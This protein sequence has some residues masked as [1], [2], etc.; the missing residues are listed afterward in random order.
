MGN[1]KAVKFVTSF[2]ES[3]Q[4][5]AIPDEREQ[6]CGPAS[7]PGAAL[8]KQVT[9]VGAKLGPCDG[10]NEARRAKAV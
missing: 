7:Q 1:P 2:R 3:A 6:P 10:V 9:I 5:V 4:L 8:P